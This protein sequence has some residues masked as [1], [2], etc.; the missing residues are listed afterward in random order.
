MRARIAI[1][2]HADHGELGDDLGEAARQATERVGVHHLRTQPGTV[3]AVDGDDLVLVAF[4]EHHRG[5]DREV[6]PLG[7]PA[8]AYRLVRLPDPFG[9][10]AHREPLGGHDLEA[11]SEVLPPAHDR[12]VGAAEGDVDGSVIQMDRKR[13]ELHPGGLVDHVDIVGEQS[14]RKAGGAAHIDQQGRLDDRQAA[15]VDRKVRAGSS[16]VKEPSSIG[17]GDHRAFLWT[18]DDPGQV[19]VRERGQH[20]VVHYVE[21]TL[22]ERQVTTPP[23]VPF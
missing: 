19:K 7:V 12:V 6:S 2:E 16:L 15:R 21:G 4:G 14:T 17:D 1:E 8:D 10:V 20:E 3:V 23:Q 22:G 13:G 11:H 18:R 5:V 9:Q